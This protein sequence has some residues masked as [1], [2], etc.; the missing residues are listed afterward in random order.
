MAMLKFSR[1]LPGGSAGTSSPRESGANFVRSPSDLSFLAA[2]SSFSLAG[3][4]L[5]A[6]GRTGTSDMAFS[7][8]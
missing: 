7:W 1:D 8:L 5:W 4:P 2:A 3:M 6:S